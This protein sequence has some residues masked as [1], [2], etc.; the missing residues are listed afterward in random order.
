MPKKAREVYASLGKRGI[1][2]SDLKDGKNPAYDKSPEFL[3]LALTMLLNTGFTRKELMTA[4]VTHLKW[5]D[6][7][8]QSHVGMVIGLLKPLGLITE[9]GG[10]FTVA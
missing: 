10:R 9:T 3:D 4:F 7:T 6:G 1:N 8:A 5:S 2:L